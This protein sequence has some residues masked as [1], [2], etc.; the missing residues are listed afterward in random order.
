VRR[1]ILAAALLVALAGL[2]VLAFARER[3]QR[4]LPA[5][6]PPQAALVKPD[7]AES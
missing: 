5:A 6:A 7:A 2:V 4:E 1:A 3:A